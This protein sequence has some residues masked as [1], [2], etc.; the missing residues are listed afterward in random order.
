MGGRV[1]CV[2]RGASC[3][4]SYGGRCKEPGAHGTH[5]NLVAKL[6]L[7]TNLVACGLDSGRPHE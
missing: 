1:T 2:T 4:D 3:D 6:V 7:V 5:G